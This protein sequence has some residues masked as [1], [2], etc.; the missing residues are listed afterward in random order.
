MLEKLRKRQDVD[1]CSYIQLLSHT[2]AP[3][4]LWYF[5]SSTWSTKIFCR[6][7]SEN[8]TLFQAMILTWS[9]LA[10]QNE[11]FSAISKWFFI[12]S[13]YTSVVVLACTLSEKVQFQKEECR[14]V[15]I[16]IWTVSKLIIKT[17]FCGNSYFRYIKWVFYR[18][19]R[20][21]SSAAMSSL[22]FFEL[23]VHHAFSPFL[24]YRTHFE[25]AVRSR[26]QIVK[27]AWERS[28]RSFQR[29][30]RFENLK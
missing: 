26:F 21:S 30:K 6:W 29:L 22:F 12:N 19:R 24:Y 23:I 13:W 20:F 25:K 11:C 1:R 9:L 5:L 16:P 3:V 18:S 8:A 4:S 17:V 15:D 14:N 2:Q 28:D 7:V 27:R 10:D